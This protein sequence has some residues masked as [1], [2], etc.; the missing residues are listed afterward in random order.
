MMKVKNMLRKTSVVLFAMVLALELMPLNA[1]TAYA[2]D[3]EIVEKVVEL[4]KEEQE[5]NKAKAI[6]E[7][8]DELGIVDED[9]VGFELNAEEEE[10]EALKSQPFKDSDIKTA[11]IASENSP[12]DLTL[13]GYDEETGQLIYVSEPNDSGYV[14]IL[15]KDISDTGYTY[16]N[17]YIGDDPTYISGLS[18]LTLIGTFSGSDQYSFSKTLDMKQFDV[19]YH[20]IYVS[21]SDGTETRYASVKFVPTYIYES[22]SNSLD[23]YYT[24]IKKFTYKYTGSTYYSNSGEYL[25]MYMDYRKKGGEWSSY[26]FRMDSS[27][28]TYQEGGLK[29]NTTYQVRQMLGKTFEYDGE[30][31]TFTGRQTGNASPAKTIKT[32]YKKP[33]VSKIKISKVKQ[34]C[35]KYRVQYAWRIWYNKRTGVI[36]K[37]KALYHTYRYWYT[38]FKVT[39]KFKK[40]QGVSGIRIDTIRGLG[41]WKN[42]NKKSYS[43]TFRV[44]GKKKGKMVTVK[45]KSCRNKTYGGWSKYLKKKVR[46]R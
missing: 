9:E 17:I 12:N 18:D 26:V 31:Y 20:T 42:G 5:E 32:A 11:P 10:N 14:S 3:D 40:K 27:N 33:K 15:S 44:N 13:N 30:T 7:L 37:R 22:V 2:A 16:Q 1:F 23:N 28:T 35:H 19:G 4:S 41:V 46:C 24:Y 38:R 29:P 39:V 36:V 45:V 21:V 43:Q 6:A 25:S 34:W 8:E